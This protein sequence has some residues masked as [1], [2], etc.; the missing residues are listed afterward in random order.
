MH[1]QYL[2]NV[3]QK[4][5]FMLAIMSALAGDAHISFEGNLALCRF[6]KLP[7]SSHSETD[8]LRRNTANPVLDFVVIPLEPDSVETIF[9]RIRMPGLLQRAIIHTQIE[10]SGTLEF[11]A[12]DN[13]H[14]ECVVVG[15]RV[16]RELL[17]DLVDKRVLRSYS[18][19]P[20]RAGGV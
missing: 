4:P 15:S 13:F 11:G 6:D 16:S 8:A 18:E 3:R 17:D 5:E 9:K 1:S 14:P 19:A 2:L 20:P 12:Y 7:D 10:K